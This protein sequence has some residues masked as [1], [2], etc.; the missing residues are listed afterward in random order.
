MEHFCDFYCGD[1]QCRMFQCI[2]KHGLIQLRTVQFCGLLD[3]SVGRKDMFM[4][5]MGHNLTLIRAAGGVDDF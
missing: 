1:G 5:S 3:N 2:P 4:D